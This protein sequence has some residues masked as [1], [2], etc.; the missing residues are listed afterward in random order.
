MRHR[1]QITNFQWIPQQTLDFSSF[2]GGNIS[3]ANK[4]RMIIR[5]RP[6]FCVCD[7]VSQHRLVARTHSRLVC[8]NQCLGFQ[9]ELTLA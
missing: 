1:S 2:V 6:A 8:L 5:A 3:I 9:T 7:H 4:S